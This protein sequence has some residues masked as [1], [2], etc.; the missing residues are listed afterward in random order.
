MTIERG[1]LAFA[2]FYASYVAGRA[3]R[4]Q[5]AAVAGYRA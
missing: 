5:L 3:G 4:R 2:G 1:G